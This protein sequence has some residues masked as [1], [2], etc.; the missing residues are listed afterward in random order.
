MEDHKRNKSYYSILLNAKELFWKYGISRVTVDEICLAA[1]LSKMSFYRNFN[2]KNELAEKVLTDE[3]KKGFD[4]YQKIMSRSI[5]FPE[6]IKKIVLLKHESTNN[7]S[8]EFI[9]DI[10]QKNE[11]EL[12]K[13]I[14]IYTQKVTQQIWI[15]FEEAQKDGWI[16]ADVKVEFLIQMMNTINEKLFDEKLKSLYDNTHDLI[17]E[18]TNFYFYGIM[19]SDKQ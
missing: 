16:R 7:I 11:A 14:D 8:E 4:D 15:D 6:K 17:M 9:K 19:K 3:L 5:S 1:G 13:L 2:N 12:T 10:Y 18:L